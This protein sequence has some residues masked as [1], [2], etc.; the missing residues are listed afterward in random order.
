MLQFLVL[1]L[2]LPESVGPGGL[3][4][5]TV[6][7]LAL[8]LVLSG[9]LGQVKLDV[10]VPTVS[11]E[12]ATLKHAIYILR[13]CVSYALDMLKTSKF[14]IRVYCHSGLGKNLPYTHPELVVLHYQ[15]L[16]L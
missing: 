8:E 16:K 1:V 12:V 2:V 13:S 9:V 15:W 3:E 10:V 5:A 11:L 14:R 4:G 7:L 6:A